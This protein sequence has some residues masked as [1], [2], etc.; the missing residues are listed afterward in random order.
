LDDEV[1]V[2]GHDAVGEQVEG[3]ISGGAVDR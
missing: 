3:S 2:V 1:Q